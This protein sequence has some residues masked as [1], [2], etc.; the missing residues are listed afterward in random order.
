MIRLPAGPAG[1]RLLSLGVYRPARVVDNA[2]IA[3]M[4]ETSDEWIQQRSGIRERRWAGPDESVLAMATAAARDALLGANL[5]GDAI[6]LV[7]LTTMSSFS[8]TPTV[9]NLLQAAIG[10]HGGALE[11][12]SACAG[13]PYALAVA[14]QAVRTG[15]ARHVLVVGVERMT[16][17]LDMAD[18]ATMFLFGDGAGAVVVGP[19]DT[20]GV[21]PVVWGSW[22]DQAEALDVAPL[23]SDVMHR[24]AEGVPVLRMKGQT[25]FRWAVTEMPKVCVEALDAAGVKAEQL[26]AFV[27]HQANTRII[28]AMV[29]GMR[30]PEHVAVADDVRWTGNTSAA[31]IPLAMERLLRDGAAHPGDLALLVG[32]GGGLS[33]AAQ[34]VVLPALPA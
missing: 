11:M 32:F 2:E 28:D 1:S 29:K 3:T 6:D 4:V 24:T 5:T 21:G 8:T 7:L 15:S 12:N 10:S 31:S 33:H 34:V 17:L 23:L 27:P 25:V 30:L 19:A 14:D 26:A 16:D 22:G 13:F 18:R 9:A 20:P